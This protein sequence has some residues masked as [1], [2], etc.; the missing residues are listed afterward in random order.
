V[1]VIGT[2]VTPGVHPLKTD[3]TLLSALY[4]AGG[5]AKYADL[6][7]VKVVHQ[8]VT[9]PYDVT[10]LTNGDL[11]QNNPTLTDGDTV[12]VPQGHHMDWTPLWAV[13]GGIAA[14][15]VSGL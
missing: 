9:K 2:V 11:S 15:L 3:P 1:N 7:G 12:V 10:K 14:G 8:G 6:K 4:V 13:L 5:P